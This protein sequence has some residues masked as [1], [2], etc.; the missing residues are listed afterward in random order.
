ML[1]DRNRPPTDPEFDNKCEIMQMELWNNDL[2][3]YFT[4]FTTLLVIFQLL[5][6][7]SE[8]TRIQ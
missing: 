8:L 1:E 6:M 4:I 5:L 3:T 2:E 7:T